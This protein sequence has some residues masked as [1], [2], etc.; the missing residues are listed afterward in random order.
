MSNPT[1]PPAAVS[2]PP[3]VTAQQSIDERLRESK[4]QHSCLRRLDEFMFCMS[5]TNQLSKYYRLG[6][7]DDCTQHFHRMQHCARSRLKKPLDS[8]ALLEEERRKHQTGTHVFLFR[9]EYAGEARHRYGIEQFAT[10]K[11]EAA[12]K[13]PSPF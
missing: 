5:V 11:G 3:R 9:P 6:T 12:E 8:E 10:P 2:P 13:N 4:A 1:S 7:Y